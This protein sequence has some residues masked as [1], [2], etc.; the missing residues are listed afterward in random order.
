MPRE[1]RRDYLYLADIVDSARTVARWL[2]EHD[3]Q[4]D[5]DEILRNAVLRQLSVIGEAASSLSED[6]RKRLADISLARSTRIPQHRD[7]RLLQPRLG[8]CA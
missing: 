1:A 8:H 3:G 6:V 2:A 7:S 5:D 4:W